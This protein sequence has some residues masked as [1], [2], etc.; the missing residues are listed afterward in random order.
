MKTKFT[1]FTGYISFIALIILL[2]L[3]SYTFLVNTLYNE[4][5]GLILLSLEILAIFDIYYLYKTKFWTVETF[6][7]LKLS[8][9]I[10]TLE[11]K[12][13]KREL[14]IKLEE[15]NKET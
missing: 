1:V 7:Q 13:Q 2:L 12:I 6:D 15:L 8:G 11:K 4:P 5:S 3:G 9:E 14:E 10:K